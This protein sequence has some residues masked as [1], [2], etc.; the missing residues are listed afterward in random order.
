MDNIFNFLMELD[1]LK[2]VYRRSYLSDYSRTENS[3]EHSWHLAIALLTFKEEFKDLED[4]HFIKT[5]KMALIHDICEIGAG[6]ISIFDPD[7]SKKETEE[8]NYIDN[9]VKNNSKIKFTTEIK[10][11]W[12]E[13]ET[14]ETKE[15]KWV[16]IADRFLP[17]I[18]NISTEG[19]TWIEQGVHKD[20]VI[21]V[22]QVVKEEAPEIFDWVMKKIDMAVQNGWLKE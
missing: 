16:K 12:E 19:K 18:M 20:Q 14:Q 15:S 9:L 1:K 17:F 5:I 13:Y 4:I 3:A 6:D 2:S 21:K 8:R 22:N 10:N 11:L 7:R